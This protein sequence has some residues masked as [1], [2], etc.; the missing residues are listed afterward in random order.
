MGGASDVPER[1]SS[2]LKRRASSMDAETKEPDTNEEDVDMIL[3]LPSDPVDTSNSQPQPEE[4]N[5]LPATMSDPDSKMQTE[6]TNETALPSIV[7][8][9]A[10]QPPSAPEEHIKSIRSLVEEMESSPL[11]E[12]QQCYIISRQWLEKVPDGSSS[13]QAVGDLSSIPPVDNS[14]L[15][16]EVISDPCVGD[17]VQD[18]LKKKFVRLKQGYDTEQF[19]AFP[20]A[21]WELLMQWPG[22]KEGQIPIV[23]YAHDNSPRQ[24]GS[25]I[26]WEWHPLVL[27]I[28]RLWSAHSTVPVEAALKASNPPPPRLVRSRSFNFQT[29][30]K[31]AKKVARIDLGQR[32][33]AWSIPQAPKPAPSNNTIGPTPPTSPE[34]DQ[35]GGNASDH[36]DHLL[37]DVE[38]FLALEKGVERELIDFSDRSHESTFT[39]IQTLG[40]LSLLMDQPIVIDPHEAG[41]DWTSNFT[42]SKA[43]TALPT[44]NSSAS[45]TVQNRNS[46]SGRTSPAS[47][48]PL[49]RGR[50]NR[51]GRTPGCVGLGNMGN[52]CYMNAALQCVRSVEELTKYFLAGDWEKELNK[53]NPLAHNGDVAAAYAQL[54]REIYKDSTP[55]SVTPRQFKNTIGKYSTGFSGYGQQDSQEF[56]GFLLDGLQEDL[57]RIKK[58][59]Y[60]E[61]PDSTD[62]MI[63]DPEAIRRMADQVWDITKRRDDSVIA[64]LF[65]GLYKSTLVCPE[66]SKVSITFDPFNNLTLPLPVGNKFN[67]TIKFFPLNDRPINIRVELDRHSSI[68]ALKDFV[69]TRTGVPVERL[70]GSEEWKGRFY[71]HYA[72][73]ACA[74]EEITT[75]DNAWIFELEAKPTNYGEKPQ[76]Q[77]RLGMPIRSMVDDEEHNSS[78]SWDDKQAEKLLVPVFH[79][80]PDSK[81][82]S[83]HSH[84]WTACCA[85]H[86]IIVT[87]QEARNEDAIRRKVLEKVATLTKHPNFGRQEDSDGSDNTEPEMIGPNGSDTGSSIG[88]K[89]VAQ[90]VKGEDDMV[91]VQMKDAGDVKSVTPTYQFN[92][93]RPA[94]VDPDKF[95][96]SHLQNL[97]EMGYYTEGSSWLPTGMNGISEDKSYPKLS[98]RAIPESP[99][100]EDHFD[101]ATNGTASNEESSSD[102]AERR[103]IESPQTRMNDESDEDD[104]PVKV[105]SNSP[106]NW[107][108]WTFKM[109]QLVSDRQLLTYCQSFTHR[110]KASRQLKV[111]PKS[112][113]GRRMKK[114]GKNAKGK[115]KKLRQQQRQQ[116]HKQQ[117]IEAEDAFDSIESAPDGGPLIRLK[118]ALVVDWSMDAYNTYFVEDK[119]LQ[120]E[121][122]LDSWDVCETLPDPELDRAQATRAKRKRDG[123]SLEECLDEFEREEILSEQDMWYCPRCKEHRRASKKFDL[124]KTPDILI[125]HLKRFSSSGF[126][127]DKLEALVDFPT[128]NLDITKRVLQREEGKE[129][130]YDL[131]GVDCHYGGLGGGHYTAYAKN[132]VDDQ[133]YS[134]NGKYHH[135]SVSKTSSDR[136]VDTSAYLLFYRRRSNIPLGGPRFRQILEKFEDD[137]SDSELP[138]SGEGQRLGEGF[139]Q[140][141][142][143]SAFQGAGAT[144][145]H[146]NHGGNSNMSVPATKDEDDAPILLRD[147]EDEGIDLGDDATRTTG[148]HPLTGSNTWNFENLLQ[149]EGVSTGN[150]GP[151]SPLG[152]GVASNEA[153]HDSSGDEGVVSPLGQDFEEDYPGMS[154]YELPSQPEGDPPSYTEPPEPEYQGGMSRD[155]MNSIWNQKTEVHEV[156]PQNENEQKSEDAAEIHIDDDDKIKFE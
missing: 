115:G 80:R 154:H 51:S 17:G 84:R 83:F 66:C 62:E 12:N 112:A 141:G 36:W 149:D 102:E 34:H 26:M 27:T 88:G 117:A 107:S 40:S 131:I 71:K 23:R 153:Q 99:S 123:I 137:V 3:A 129:E 97:F 114:Y 113:G 56:L 147:V 109:G 124:W 2:P 91:D 142:S 55:S 21:A 54:L 63:N 78:A 13:K 86:F 64:D 110:Q 139:S 11:K 20:P 104:S 59:P 41:T 87:P 16:L 95:L 156:L 32:I 126:R 69:S 121:H 45:L 108:Q 35:G 15:I 143:S 72:D 60:I 18:V 65:T 33:R 74:S 119:T 144:H 42:T 79:R 92:R 151:D 122:S 120:G 22:L 76:K 132:F 9:S 31:Q 152:S 24:D 5:G 61:K 138:E 100:S 145:L 52:T 10:L 103:S 67:H 7:T 155:D 130:V 133:W 118:E 48:G 140:D 39:S 44:R 75:N 93:R 136:I 101:N 14:D 28:H 37:L 6:A 106:Y 70:F 89:V 38:S 29:F 148:F 46:R 4:A 58:K 150:G 43:T 30:L 68:K 127:R 90:S 81:R 49:T 19:V 134:Y 77:Q 125:I 1:A 116:K 85:P 82:S 146:G 94:W 8:S 98:S 96:P 53:Q 135:S 111:N 128:E 73:L 105:F 57:S 47:Q 50:T 25:D